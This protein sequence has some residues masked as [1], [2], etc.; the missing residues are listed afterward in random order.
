MSHP[1]VT[2]YIRTK[3]IGYPK[4]G[5]HLRIKAKNDRVTV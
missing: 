1:K 5:L 4:N 3:K 2:P